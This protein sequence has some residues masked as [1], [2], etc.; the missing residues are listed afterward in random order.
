MKKLF[1]SC[2][3]VFILFSCKD[4]DKR[5]TAIP[6]RD[7]Q[8]Q[9]PDS[10]PTIPYPT[11]IS[12]T[13]KELGRLQQEKNADSLSKMVYRA[14]A[15]EM[16]LYWKGTKWDFNG[17]TKIPGEGFIACGYFITTV[18]DD[19]GLKINRVRLAQEP[20][21][22]LIQSTCHKIKTYAGFAALKTYLDSSEDETIFIAGLDFHTGFIIKQAGQCYFFHFNYINKMGVV[23][24]LIDES[25]ALKNSQS[26][27]I[28]NLTGNKSYLL[29]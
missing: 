16:P 4:K 14:I 19:I 25:K 3:T 2:V 5:S 7:D 23:K 1:L 11:F 20:S 27:M 24:E 28:G 13:K 26:F 8:R 21:S 15:V 17:A 9:L 29:K 6:G 18:L 10:K 12:L 22:V